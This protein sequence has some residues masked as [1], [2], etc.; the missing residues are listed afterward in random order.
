MKLCFVSTGNA[1]LLMKVFDLFKKTIFLILFVKES[2]VYGLYWSNI[3]TIITTY[4]IKLQ[5][6]LIQTKMYKY[7]IKY[8]SKEKIIHK[9]G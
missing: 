4:M 2:N 1:I 3:F 7:S 8:F 6:K 5:I 9:G